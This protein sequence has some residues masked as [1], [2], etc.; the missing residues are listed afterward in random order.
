MLIVAAG[1]IG[2]SSSPRPPGSSWVCANSCPVRSTRLSARSDP[3]RRGRATRCIGRIVVAIV[4]LSLYD[5]SW[6]SRPRQ[7]WCHGRHL[8]AI[9]G[10]AT[11]V[12][13]TARAGGTTRP[14]RWRQ[15]DCAA[16]NAS[17]LDRCKCWPGSGLGGLIAGL[18]MSGRLD[19]ARK[20]SRTQVANAGV[21]AST[22]LTH[23]TQALCC[24][25]GDDSLP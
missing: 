19:P 14:I 4:L 17:C 8:L 9:P 16:A 21:A 11:T 10:G 12:W 5:T 23:A 22:R 24:Q 3:Q 2:F 7:R 1:S 13:P 20:P 18:V 25:Q 15:Q 6:Q